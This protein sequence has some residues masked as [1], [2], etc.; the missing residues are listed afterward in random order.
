MTSP[1]STLSIDDSIQILKAEILA[2]DWRLSASRGQRLG[3]ALS[4]LKR[5]YSSR[6]APAAILTMAMSVVDYMMKTGERVP[7]AA[8]DF[9]KEALAHVV[10]I[11]EQADFVPEEEEQLFRTVYGRFSLLKGR[12]GAGRST[13]TPPPPPPKA[14]T[15]GPGDLP[16]LLAALTGTLEQAERLTEALRAAVAGLSQALPEPPLPEK[17]EPAP[18]AAVSPP[19]AAPAPP[20]SRQPYLATEV[21]PLALGNEILGVPESYVTL[22]KDLGRERMAAYARESRVPARDFKR[23]FGRLAGAFRGPLAELPEAVLRDLV[24]PVLVPMGMEMPQGPDPE[25]ATV[26]LLSNGHRHGALLC[27]EVGEEP[28]ALVRFRQGA[29][30]DLAGT[31]I[32]ADGTS[33][34]LVDVSD[35]LRREGHLT[36]APEELP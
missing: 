12:L 7:P 32:L 30:G 8:V 21:R 17:A 35:L 22:V 11:H 36:V 23:L 10:G 9:L 3:E 26:L 24:F 4:C 31:A 5:R 6:K 20:V 25:A 2:P 33:V 1:P 13:A 28:M 18:E 34:R 19:A 14:S 16:S 29:D 15:A 27:A